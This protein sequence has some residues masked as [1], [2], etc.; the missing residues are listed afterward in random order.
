MNKSR[1]LYLAL[2]I[3][4]AA[5]LGYGLYLEHVL[6]Q[7]PCPLCVL[8]RIAYIVVAVIALVAA[9]HGPSGIMN[10]IYSG[11]IALAAIA[12]GGI[13]GRQVWLQ[14][15]P[16]DQVPECGPGYDYLMDVFPLDEA[17]GMI[18]TGSGECAEV[19]WTFLGLSIA[20]WS[21][22][23]FVIILLAA[24]WILLTGGRKAR[25]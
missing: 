14:H 13:A 7:E 19:D 11:L 17:L 16:P 20:E 10:R 4:C 1:L 15:L 5:L 25:T 24:L 8:Q 23:M 2:F 9:I 6:G 3:V 22:A 21:L 18:F 12:G